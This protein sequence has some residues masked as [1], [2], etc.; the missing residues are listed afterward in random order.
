MRPESV[1]AWREALVRL[2]DQHFFDLMRLYLGAVKTP[3]NKQKL[4]EELSAMMRREETRERMV[5][6]LDPLDL[7]ILAAIRELPSPTHGRVIALFG[8]EYSFAELYERILNL[9]ERLVIFRRDGEAERVYAVNPYLEDRVAAIAGRDVLVSPELVG[10]PLSVPPPVDSLS[11]AGLFSFF[12]HNPDPVKGD[13]TFRKKTRDALVTRFP[14]CAAAEGCLDV[15]VSAFLNLGLLARRDGALVPDPAR[16][17]AFAAL[18]DAERRA[19]LV[20]AAQGRTTR[21]GLRDR[22]RDALEFA[23]SLVPGGAYAPATVRRLVA[24]IS[25]RSALRPASRPNSRF[26]AILRHV[27]AS[28]ADPGESG[29]PGQREGEGTD[30]L[31]A[32]LAFGMVAETEGGV[33]ANEIPEA[34]EPVS[35]V[36]SPAFDVTVMPGAPLAE[37]IPLA[38]ILEVEGVQTAGRFLLTKRS[39][40]SAFDQGLDAAEVIERLSRGSSH[41]IPGNVR[42]TVEDWYR[43]WSSVSLYHG[44]VL[45]VDESRR[46]AFENNPA[47]ADLVRLRLAPGVWLLD[48]DSAEAAQAA[49]AEAGVDPVPSLSAP[50][51]SHASPPFPPVSAP[52]A[53]KEASPRT[54]GPRRATA[55][56]TP[57]ATAYGTAARAESAGAAGETSPAAPVAAI[58]AASPPRADSIARHRENLLAALDALELS[59]DAREALLSRI[60]RRVVLYPEQLDP[61]SVRMEKVEARGM[62][63]LG[64][65]RIVEYAIAS[66]SLLEIGLDESEGQRLILGRPL[67]IEKRQ[68]D[69]SVRIALEPDRAVETVSVG[70][71]LLVRRIRGSIFSELTQDR[72]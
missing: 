23:A 59:E 2:A 36:V 50:V 14:D 27:P 19:Y 67:A 39:A 45:R 69:V 11:L 72:L 20:A 34:G 5:S 12:L 24:L 49:L 1:V 21:E 29:D 52:E 26:A 61:A 60:E 33:G 57:A 55:A 47:I 13:G 70:R 16:W 30:L 41:D 66:G 35:F 64:K 62:D 31:A 65:V 71:A 28:P 8:G 58:P 7:L 53:G 48:A 6:L 63:F 37:L 42:F 25:S 43:A 68:G 3:F 51:S 22:A 38:R 4:V 32:A 10:P 17:E 44:Y 15:L 54:A 46:A 18:G 40:S 56:P 9:E